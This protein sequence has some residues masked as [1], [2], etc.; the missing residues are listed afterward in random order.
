VEID[1]VYR[2]IRV[3]ILLGL[4]GTALVVPSIGVACGLGFL[5]GWGWMTLNLW[6]LTVL[7]RT[8]FSESP[9]R[10]KVMVLL[11]LKFPLLYAGGFLLVIYGRL[12]VPGALAG[13]SLPLVVVLLKAA[14]ILLQAR[15]RVRM[16]SAKPPSEPDRN[17]PTESPVASLR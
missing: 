13:F 8:A 7:V 15:S 9:D 5:A 10:K 2:V 12:D 17:R 1:F 6:L 16:A 11:F 4:V 14:G 3:S